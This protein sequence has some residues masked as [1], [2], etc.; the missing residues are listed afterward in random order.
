ML[1]CADLLI[2]TLQSLGTEYIFSLS[3]NQI[4]PIYD[5]WI[6]SE[7]EMIHTRHESGAVHMADAWGRL[8]GTPGVALIAGG[9]GFANGLSAM[10]VAQMAESPIVV[11]SGH[12]GLNHIGRGM[13]QEMDQAEMATA[14]S[15]HSIL[16]QNPNDIEGELRKA[17]QIAVDGRPGPVH[18]SLPFDL[19][20]MEV[21]ESGMTVSGFAPTPTIKNGDLDG[22][23]QAVN[24]AKRPLLIAGSAVMRSNKF[25]V[26]KEKLAAVNVPLIGTESPRGIDDPSKGK[27]ASVLAQADLVLL[28]GKKLDFTLKFGERPFFADKSKLI[29]IDADRDVLELSRRN[30]GALELVQ[31]TQAEPIDA[32]QRLAQLA[33][34]MNGDAGWMAEVET[35]VSFTPPEWKNLKSEN[36]KALYSAEV[37][38]AINEYLMDAEDSILISD[39]GEFGQWMQALVRPPHRVINGM[40]GSIGNAIPFGVAARLAFPNSRVVA[41]SGDGAFGFLP[42]EMETAVR[43]NIP[44]ITVIGNDSRWNAEY[45]IQKRKYG[46]DRVKGVDLNSIDYHRVVEVLGGWGQQVTDFDVLKESLVEAGNSKL[47][48]CINA[49]IR[50]EAAP[51]LSETK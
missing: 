2:Q 22:V 27:F 26:I 9:P 3:G 8:I 10:Y 40:S 46:A 50:G 6:D 7:M 33:N 25:R 5:A 17:F 39:G 21:G 37:G 44:F 42:F 51:K 18:L 19:L 1:R 4:M 16:L 32:L 36:G 13:F 14:V 41:C 24:G 48:A 23:L 43:Y 29:Q 11:L 20:E 34:K 30:G 28:L 47:P 35:A 12:V 15:K 49:T 45:Q 38:Y 31:L